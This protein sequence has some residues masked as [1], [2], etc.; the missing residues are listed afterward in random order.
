MV[1]M[2]FN[3]SLVALIGAGEQPLFSPR[4]LQVVNTKVNKLAFILLIYSDCLQYVN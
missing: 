1:E 3:T 4:K 2:L